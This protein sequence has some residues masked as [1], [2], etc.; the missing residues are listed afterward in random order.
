M[1]KLFYDS[2]ALYA[3]LKHDKREYYYENGQKKTVENYRNGKLHGDVELF[4]PNGALKRKCTFVDGVRVGLDQMWDE[5]G[6]LV[7][8]ERY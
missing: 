8:E 7:D 6:K 4:W 5:M 3:D 1:D 2:G